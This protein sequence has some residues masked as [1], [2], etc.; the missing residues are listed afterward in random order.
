MENSEYFLKLRRI[1][2][3]LINTLLIGTHDDIND[4]IIKLSEKSKENIEEFL[5]YLYSDLDRIDDKDRKIAKQELYGSIIKNDIIYNKLF[6]DIIKDIPLT[7]TEESLY[8]SM[9]DK[10]ENDF[11]GNVDILHDIFSKDDEE[12]QKFFTY[13]IDCRVDDN[14]DVFNK[15][16]N[17]DYRIKFNDILRKISV[18]SVLYN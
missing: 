9:S 8:D 16:K 10:L 15:I 6:G 5:R 2:E 11:E 13:Y 17:T 18:D 7:D 12:I 14:I 3:D 1:Y 4:Y